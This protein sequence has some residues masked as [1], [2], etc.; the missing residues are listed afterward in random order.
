MYNTSRNHRPPN[1][2]E[3]KS[4]DEPLPVILAGPIVRRCEYD[5][6]N[7]TAT[8]NIW[9][10]TSKNFESITISVSNVSASGYPIMITSDTNS[11]FQNI[12]IS[13]YFWVWMLK[14]KFN[15]GVEELNNNIVNENIESYL[16]IKNEENQPSIIINNLKISP[17]FSKS[18][19]DENWLKK[20]IS[21]YPD[22][23]P[24]ASETLFA[25]D[26]HFLSKST[27]VES[28]ENLSSYK[29]DSLAGVMNG[30]ISAIT[31]G[32]L[33]LPIFS[34]Q[35]ENQSLKCLFGS[36]RKAHGPGKDASIGMGIELEQALDSEDKEFP[37]ALFLTGDQ[38]YADDVHNS[39][40]ATI[41]S[42]VDKLNIK[43]HIE[44]PGS[45]DNNKKAYIS[46]LEFDRKS[47]SGLSGFT[48]T[49]S[50]NHLRDFGEFS[51]LYLIMWNSNLWNQNSKIKDI[52]KD[53]YEGT[54]SIRRVLA[55]VPTYMIIDDHDVTDDFYF[56]D[57]WKTKVLQSASGRRIV[58]HA[59]ANYWLFQAWG[60][61]FEGIPDNFSEMINGYTMGNESE[62]Y[63]YDKTFTEYHEWSFIS[64]TDPPAIFLNTRTQRK[65][66]KE[67][68]EEY[69]ET[70]SGPILIN[71]AEYKILNTLMNDQIGD[72]NNRPIVFVSPSPIL[73][74]SAV[75][76]G[77]DLVVKDS[78]A[79]DKETFNTNPHTFHQFFQFIKTLNPSHLIII[80]GDVH[81]ATIGYG[82]LRSLESDSEIYI[83]QFT[84]S[85]L[86]NKIDHWKPRYGLM[87]TD[88]QIGYLHERNYY[89][90]RNGEK[91]DQWKFNEKETDTVFADYKENIS[92]FYNDLISDFSL[93]YDFVSTNQYVESSFHNKAYK[94]NNFGYLE[95]LASS[96][97]VSVSIRNSKNEECVT[98]EGDTEEWPI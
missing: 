81:Y 24:L 92:H 16:K 71:N 75:E 46:K 40:L 63:D 84:S 15:T 3:S 38:I 28:G 42:L 87:L 96:T 82:E 98:F 83:S 77:I 55:N 36:C 30:D 61:T 76:A 34:V 13:D 9:L 50:E 17:E 14:V 86:K 10:A 43:K 6:S 67:A 60:N 66:E 31:L 33:E 23:K 94:N 8:V 44:G 25:Y 91:I 90:K 18:I 57:K 26:I 39:L 53:A 52:L 72:L 7:E 58:S 73:T 65:S 22:P 51:A 45:H 97:K 89:Y 56:D 70:I 78:L 74:L 5:S 64:P 27:I 62:Q 59:L 35:I 12:Q 79:G 68:E 11:T 85:A 21:F 95:K 37:N 49:D 29:F 69:R 41:E 54:K 88:N 80:S 93:K 2:S 48:S 19:P 4:I 32:E 20:T 1:G 47:Y